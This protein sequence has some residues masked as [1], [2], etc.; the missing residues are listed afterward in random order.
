MAVK[1]EEFEEADE[2]DEVDEVEAG[3]DAT[4]PIEGMEDFG[5]DLPRLRGL[6]REKHY[7]AMDLAVRAGMSAN[8][9]HKL[10]GGKSASVSA[11]TVFRLAIALKVSAE[12]L[13]GLS[14]E[15]GLA[16]TVRPPA[17]GANEL[18]VLAEQ[19]PRKQVDM[20]IE[21][22]R[23]FVTVNLDAYDAARAQL[24]DFWERQTQAGRRALQLPAQ[25]PAQPAAQAR[26]LFE[27]D[28]DDADQDGGA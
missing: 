23:S 22:G 27:D 24:N 20:L 11:E 17:Y 19:L 18:A 5:I 26:R 25:R 2:A 8:T 12:Y 28:E 7:S 9:I 13:V 21:I 6:M 3:G 14:G 4:D 1:E 10:R 16:P 15:R